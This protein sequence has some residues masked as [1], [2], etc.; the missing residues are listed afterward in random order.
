M[1]THDTPEVIACGFDLDAE[2]VA[3][4]L[5]PEPLRLVD[6]AVAREAS[7]KLRADP[8]DLW[9]WDIAWVV[10]PCDWPT[11]PLWAEIDAPMR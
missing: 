2:F 9:R 1:T 8:A 6:V 4:L 5:A 11:E 7:R 3:E 10:G